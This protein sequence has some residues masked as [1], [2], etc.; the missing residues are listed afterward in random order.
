ML[1]EALLY[2]KFDRKMLMKLKPNRFWQT[3]LDVLKML[4]VFN[5][6]SPD[7]CTY[8]GCGQINID[9]MIIFESLLTTFEAGM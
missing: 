8:I 4:N 2:E 5:T 1:C 6:F 3:I 9:E 7:Y